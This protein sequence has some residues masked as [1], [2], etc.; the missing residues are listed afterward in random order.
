MLE[1]VREH[2]GRLPEQLS[3]DTGYLSER[4]ITYCEAHGVD[5]YIAVRRNEDDAAQLGR[6]PMS[7]AQAPRDYRCSTASLRPA[8]PSCETSRT[9]FD[10][11]CTSPR[12]ISGTASKR[13]Q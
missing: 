9:P 3:A 2:C 10:R 1:R 13:P 12:S 5:V 4:N 8:R 6:F 11:A 7:V